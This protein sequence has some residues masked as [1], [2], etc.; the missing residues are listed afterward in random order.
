MLERAR[1]LG[2]VRCY[3]TRT[4]SDDELVDR[5]AGAEAV[6]NVRSYT[7]FTGDLLA[8]LPSLRL[9]SILG[10]GTDNVDLAACERRG[11]TVTNTPAASTRSVVEL[12]VALMF[13][14]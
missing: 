14:A 10:T 3:S 8:R 6:I 11:V 4:A 2:E 9:I 12:T 7:R 5:L 1:R 13:A